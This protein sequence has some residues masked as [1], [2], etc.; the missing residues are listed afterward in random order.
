MYTQASEGTR[1]GG[2]L[3]DDLPREAG[4]AP[5]GR[6]GELVEGVGREIEVAEGTP[7]AAVRQLHL[8]RLALVC[9]WCRRSEGLR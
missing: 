3:V 7:L 5:N 8:D 2:N 4:D 1:E 6:I 9:D